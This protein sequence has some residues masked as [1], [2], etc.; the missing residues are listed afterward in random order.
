LSFER[1]V[2][3]NSS[4]RI[5]YSA[6]RGIGLLR[7]VQDNLPVSPLAGGIVVVNHPNNAPAAGAPDL[8]GVKIDSVAA[9]VRCAGTGFIPGVLVQTPNE[10]PC[11]TP[12]PIA[13]NEVSFRVRRTNERRPD[14]RYGTNLVVS[15]GVWSYYQ[16]LQVEWVK[17]LS[18]GLTFSA[19]YTWSKS[20]DTTSEA[21]AVGAGDSNFNG[22]DA[23][24]ARGLSRFHT[25]HRLT[26]FGT[27]RLSWFDKRDGLAGWALGGWQVSAVMKLASGIP[28]TVID[29]G[30]N[31]LNFDGFNETRPVLLDNSML[32]KSVNDPDTSQQ[33]LRR[34]AFRS[35]TFSDFGCC[36]M[37]R[38]TFFV[39]GVNN[40][41]I[42]IYKTFKMPFE[43]HRLVFRADMFNAWN[44][45]QYGFP[46]TDISASTFGRINGTSVAYAPRNVQFSL[47]YIF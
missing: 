2:P 43:N 23:R 19:A 46:V 34:D 28:F 20:I 45:A 24:A 41:D 32:G 39:D 14:P 13:N 42:G 4:L 8:R 38:N 7:Y 37:G 30:G 33:I 47:R 11:N 1:K 31:D 22:P 12:V 26:V 17:R 25:P 6:N 40:F 21:T 35:P 5:S 29:G 3:F 27:Y 16:G 9:D 44:H 15:N 10:G 36:V 18:R